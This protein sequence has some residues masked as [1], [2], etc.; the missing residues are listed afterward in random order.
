VDYLDAATLRLRV[1]GLVGSGDL[2]PAHVPPSAILV[3]RRLA[4]PLPRRLSPW[5]NFVH[6][7]GA[8]ER[9]CREALGE[10]YRTGARPRNGR[11]EGA[12]RAVLFADE[13]EL[14]ACL[15]LDLAC[16]QAAGRW[17]WK[18]LRRTGA[19]LPAEG[20][21]GALCARPR[22]VPAALHHLAAWGQA[23]TVLKQLT[24]T[25]ALT[26]LS[27]VSRTHGMADF[28]AAPGPG[29]LS[30][31]TP[32]EQPASAE[33]PRRERTPAGSGGLPALCPGPA[34]RPAMAQ[35]TAEPWSD[36]GIHHRVPEGLGKERTSLL[37]V[38]LLLH[39]EPSRVTAPAFLRAFRH[40]W[41][42]PGALQTEEGGARPPRPSPAGLGD[43][44]AGAPG[45]RVGLSGDANSGPS[46]HTGRW[47]QSPQETAQAQS[48]KGL[49]EAPHSCHAPQ[50]WQDWLTPSDTEAAPSPAEGIGTDLAGALYLVNVMGRLGLPECFEEG[51]E[52]ASRVGA[53][54]TLDALARGL[55]GGPEHLAADPL[56]AVLAAL[57]SRPPGTLPGGTLRA[58]ESPRLPPAWQGEADREA[59]GSPPGG[60]L[61]A[62][63]SPGL[64]HWLKR[65]LPFVRGW[66]RRALG[67]GAEGGDP[68]AYLR[69][70]GRLHVT[71]THVDVVFAL[72]NISLPVRQAGLDCDPGW[73]REFGRVILFHF[74]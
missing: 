44:G 48:G 2:Q 42:T 4:D 46:L 16:G 19:G 38:G 54:G 63:A 51:W 21:A 3:V 57:A 60:P 72:D 31:G 14:L 32:P 35:V 9:A 29:N 64:A 1:A 22:S 18:A 50:S 33:G 28:G 65:V 12:A 39:R 49:E 69:C 71:A 7:D 27:A 70:R 26:V 62:G 66:L 30:S 74:L 15:A 13:G 41:A 20:V 53:W 25:E 45:G 11:V 56:W 17:W 6:V 10:L 68:A 5:R 58:P 37:G 61:L 55:L 43:E 73:V 47:Q 34:V 59:G 23:V 40:W 24:P 52:L 8:W 67:P 36:W